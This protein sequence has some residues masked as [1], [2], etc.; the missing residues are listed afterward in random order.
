MYRFSIY[1]MAFLITMVCTC[2]SAQKPDLTDVRILTCPVS[3]NIY[4]LEATGD[5]AGNMAVLVGPEGILLVDS[6]FSEL[7][8][9]IRA[10]LREIHTGSIVYIINT[11]YHED[12]SDGNEALKEP[13]TT[14]IASGNT[15]KR[16]SQRPQ[17]ARPDITFD[18]TITVFFNGEEVR[19]IHLPAGHTDTDV[20]VYFTK[21]KVLHLGD[22]YNAGVSSF[23]NIDLEAGGTLSG[24]VENVGSLIDMIPAGAKI[25]PGHYELSDL[26]GLKACHQMLIDT[27]GFVKRKKEAGIPLEQIKEEGFPDKYRSWGLT[28]YTGAE[29][30][31][32][33]I[34]RGLEEVPVP[35]QS[36]D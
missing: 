8:D 3:D 13:S 30:W 24:L 33:N 5:V 10:A 23:P 17:K 28:G 34:Y 7:A 20:V 36:E 26:D 16:S 14:I 22:L 19:L 27:I 31:I 29:E 1:K 35:N 6:Q 9:S 21:S 15:R 11:H 32:E 25:I 12:H 4:M 18:S 2:G